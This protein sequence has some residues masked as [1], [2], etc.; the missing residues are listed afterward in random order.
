[1]LL[2]YAFE[3]Q[4]TSIAFKMQGCPRELNLAA[5]VMEALRYG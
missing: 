4:D 2:V 5:V 1:L 3:V